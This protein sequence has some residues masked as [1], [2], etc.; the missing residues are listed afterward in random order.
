MATETKSSG[1]TKQGKAEMIISAYIDYL[2]INGKKP[3]TVYKFCKDLGIAET[4]FYKVTNSFESLETHIWAGFMN[5][6]ITAAR[7]D[8]QFA[9]FSAR[10][11][12]LSLYFML[13]EILKQNRSFAI[14]TSGI[15][16]GQDMVP[17]CLKDF[18]SKFESFVGEIMGE[19]KSTGEVAGRPF[20]DQRYPQLF[21]LHL[22]VL[23]GYWKDD[24]STD[25]ENT[26]AFI[27]KSVNLAFDLIGKG[28]LDNAIDF[29]KFLYQSKFK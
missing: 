6:A 28:T 11:K 7:A 13:M 19:G 24:T 20:L 2:L 29:A 5:R 16:F 8:K 17:V 9:S 22:V 15:R 25:F 27:E 3:T 23:I 12:L 1:K 14:L 4:E 26:D 10:E 21:W 18:R